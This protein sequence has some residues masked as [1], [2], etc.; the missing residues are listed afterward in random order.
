MQ[1]KNVLFH[2]TQQDCVPSCS[3]Q[4]PGLIGRLIKAG[5]QVYSPGNGWAYLTLL[6]RIVV[7]GR[8]GTFD[9]APF[10]REQLGRMTQKRAKAIIATAPKE[11]AV[12]NGGIVAAEL[13]SWL[14]RAQSSLSPRRKQ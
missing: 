5:W 2:G 3:K 13:Q 1:I 7:S 4:D 8:E 12:E 11:V 14:E 9:V 10:F 6:S